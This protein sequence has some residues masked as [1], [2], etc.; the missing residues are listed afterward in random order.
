MCLIRLIDCIQQRLFLG[1][2]FLRIFG[3]SSGGV[4]LQVHLSQLELRGNAAK[5]LLCLI[6]EA[7]Q[8]Q[9]DDTPVLAVEAGTL[10]SVLLGNLPMH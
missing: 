7:D 5:Y 1:L 4:F 2:L 8:P 3:F 9:S 10:D 6:R